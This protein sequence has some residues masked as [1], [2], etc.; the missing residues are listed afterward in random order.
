MYQDYLVKEKMPL[1]WCAG[2]GDGIVLQSILRSMDQHRLEKKDTVVTT[3]IGCWSK[4]DDYIS[5]NTV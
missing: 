1:F 5:T 3:G 4:A 2:C